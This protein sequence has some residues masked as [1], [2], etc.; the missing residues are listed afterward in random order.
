MDVSEPTHWSERVIRSQQDA[1]RL[2]IHVG[3]DECGKEEKDRHPRLG[4][5]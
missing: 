3:G 4:D 2:G 1:G 5:Y